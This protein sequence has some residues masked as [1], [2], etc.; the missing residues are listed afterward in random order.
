MTKP[1]AVRYFRSN[2]RQFGFTL[3]EVLIAIGLVG[4]IGVAISQLI[5]SMIQSQSFISEKFDYLGQLREIDDILSDKDTCEDSF[6]GETV[7]TSGAFLNTAD[8]EKSTHQDIKITTLNGTPIANYRSFDSVRI[9][10]MEIQVLADYPA[11][12]VNM[13]RTRL[14]VF[15]VK[16]DGTPTIVR[17][18]PI[19]MD[20]QLDGP[21]GKIVSCST[22]ALTDSSISGP[23]S[24]PSTTLT[25]TTTGVPLPT[26]TPTT[27]APTCTSPDSK[28]FMC[29]DGYVV[30]GFDCTG[31]CKSKKMKV[32]C[33]KL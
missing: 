23:S 10:R 11:P 17:P 32:S 31:S 4:G 15:P 27:T 21:S 28:K 22:E 14:Y 1:I 19:S 9:S 24:D 30:I 33:K 25:T 12:N 29:P 8:P 26:C 16:R 7:L 5:V 6:K 3:V 2:H 20:I 18:R 13:F